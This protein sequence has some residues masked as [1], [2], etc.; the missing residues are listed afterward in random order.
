MASTTKWVISIFL[1]ILN[2]IIVPLFNF[3]VRQYI[4]DCDTATTA[5]KQCI[6]KIRDSRELSDTNLEETANYFGITNS[7]FEYEIERYVLSVNLV[8]EEQRLYEGEVYRRYSFSSDNRH[9]AKGD[10]V[11]FHCYMKSRPIL[12]TIG[13][14]F[15]GIDIPVEDMTYVVGVR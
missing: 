4:K 14:I 3:S 9:Y 11:R 10:F 15:L 1:L 8:P 13:A 12:A 2:L 5:A 7:V 6:D